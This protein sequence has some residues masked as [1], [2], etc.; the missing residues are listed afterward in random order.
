MKEPQA[1][2]RIGQYEIRSLLGKGGMGAVYLAE[3]HSLGRQVALKILPPHLSED[4]EIMARFVREARALAA[5]RHPNLMH[6]YTVGKHE[7][8]P[9]FAME[10]VKGSTLGAVLAKAKSLALPQAVHITAEV[11][12]ALDK[13]HEAG[14]VHRDVKPGNIIIDDDG[15]AVLMDFGLAR[16]E[17]DARL[18]ADHT[19]LGTPQYMSPEQAESADVDGRADVYSLG[20]VLYEM[21]T[22]SPPFKGKTSF[23]VLRQHVESSVPAPSALRPDVPAGLDVVLARAVAKSPEDR[24]RNV[25]EMAADLVKVCPDPVLARLAGVAETDTVPT[26]VMSDAAGRPRTFASTVALP[27][28][29]AWSRRRLT[30]GAAVVAALLAALIVWLMFRPSPGQWVEIRRQ[31]AEPVRGRL[32]EIEMLDDGTTTA[33]IRAGE[34]GRPTEIRIEEGDEIRVV[35]KR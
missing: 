17:Q 26:V 31:G 23:E 11:M 13:V 21:L 29:R 18:T 14:M 4:S 34:S 15:R 25:R 28:A 6:I 8:R 32:V 3:D 1:G 30:V 16:R 22:G 27:T 9:Y 24:Y 35:Q 10:Y 7:G 2:E 19:V 12:A 20:I 33:K 5:L